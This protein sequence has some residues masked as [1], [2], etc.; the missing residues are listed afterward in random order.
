M[1]TLFLLRHGKSDWDALHEADRDRP[2][3]R[4]GRRAAERMGAWFAAY[5]SPPEWVACSPAARTRATLDLFLGEA[6]SRVDVS[7]REELYES[8][9]ARYLRVMSEA[10][11]GV[12]RILVVGHEPVCSQLIEW[13][14]GARVIFPTAAMARIDL[15]G[16][17]WSETARGSLIWLL[18]ARLP[19]HKT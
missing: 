10:P 14:T 11:A 16:D 15:E 12:S 13:L 8:D 3:A 17:I 7:F 19:G 2:L 4:R 18:P 5:E 6:G 1:K 9:A